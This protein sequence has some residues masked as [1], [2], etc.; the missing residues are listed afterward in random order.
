MINRFLKCLLWLQM[1][2]I[3][4]GAVVG[5]I[6]GVFYHENVL[7]AYHCASQYADKLPA[8]LEC[9]RYAF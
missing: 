1:I 6:V 3:M 9:V 5:V 7:T 8:I 4:V 2:Q